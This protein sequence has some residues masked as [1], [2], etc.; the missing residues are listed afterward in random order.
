[1]TK[2]LNI[3]DKMIKQLNKKS[4]ILK[5]DKCNMIISLRHYKLSYYLSGVIILSLT[6]F[7]IFI[8]SV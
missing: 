8:S 5:T 6:I 1:M 7:K 4:K 3:E 2:I